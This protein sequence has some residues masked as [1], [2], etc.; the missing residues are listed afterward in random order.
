MVDPHLVRQQLK[1]I[2]ADMGLWCRAERE[3]LPK[4]LFEGEELH[5]LVTGHYNGGFAI[6]CAT[7]QRVLLV[8]KKPLYLTMEDI[9]YD[10]ISDIMFNHRF[11]NA[12]LLL[13]TV[14]K[15]ISFTGYKRDKLRDFTVFVQGKILEFRQ[16]QNQTRPQAANTY[17]DNYQEAHSHA[18]YEHSHTHTHS[19]QQDEAASPLE[20]LRAANQRRRNPYN[21]YNMPVVIRRRASKYY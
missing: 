18:P 11:L 7:N 8:D 10:M 14:H 17:N 21:M 15:S 19:D 9:R 4:L 6:L 13:G 5:H 16:G 1:N 3:E 2:G 20:I 12:T